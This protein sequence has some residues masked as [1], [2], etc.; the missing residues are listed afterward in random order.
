MVFPFSY[1]EYAAI[2]SDSSAWNETRTKV[3]RSSA[4][5][6]CNWKTLLNK[7]IEPVNNDAKNSKSSQPPVRKDK[8][9]KLK[10]DDIKLKTDRPTTSALSATKRAAS[11]KKL[12]KDDEISEKKSRST[13]N[14]PVDRKFGRYLVLLGLDVSF[15]SSPKVVDF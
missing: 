7:G 15:Y 14:E 10:V 2:M 12:S 4:E 11:T 8:K 13:F 3:P 5:F 6:S 9:M 1:Q